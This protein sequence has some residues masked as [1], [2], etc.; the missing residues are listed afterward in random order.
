MV[1]ATSARM[2][3]PLGPCSHQATL[4]ERCW[5]FWRCHHPPPDL[6]LVAEWKPELLGTG[7]ERGRHQW[8][9]SRAQDEAVMASRC[10]DRAAA[11]HPVLPC[12]ALTLLPVSVHLGWEIK[13]VCMMNITTLSN[14]SSLKLALN[15]GRGRALRCGAE[16]IT[17]F[18]HLTIPPCGC[19]EQ[20]E[21]HT[22]PALPFV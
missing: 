2:Y 13:W 11:Q 5:C 6:L 10:A 19:P 18:L 20:Q 17:A 9:S 4:L 14:H 1:W 22:V 21:R 3:G 15:A 7:W 8:R 16:S 12:S